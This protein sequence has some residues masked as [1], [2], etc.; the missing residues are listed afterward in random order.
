M[1]LKGL[2][3]RLR[4]LA[5]LAQAVSG[6]RPQP[7]DRRGPRNQRGQRERSMRSERQEGGGVRVLCVGLSAPLEPSFSL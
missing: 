2:G 6:P 4:V 5:I 7:A 3:F 1:G